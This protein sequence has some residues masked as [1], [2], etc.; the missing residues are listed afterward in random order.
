MQY[1][2]LFTRIVSLSKVNEVLDS[3]AI[4]DYNVDIAYRKM[5]LVAH[6]YWREMI[7]LLKIDS[8]CMYVY[9]KMT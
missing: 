5:S 7:K 3:M 9:N 2:F 4:D 8:Y 6:K 1:T